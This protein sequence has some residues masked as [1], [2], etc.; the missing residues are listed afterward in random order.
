MIVDYIFEIIFK[1]IIENLSI[2]L[3]IFDILKKIK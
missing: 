2:M 1:L 3:V